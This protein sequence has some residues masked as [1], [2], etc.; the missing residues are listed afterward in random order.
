[1]KHTILSH[2]VSGIKV[3]R[4]ILF[5]AMYEAC[6]HAAADLLEAT[7]IDSNHLLLMHNA[8]DWGDICNEDVA[9]NNRGLK[10][11]SMLV[12]T[13]RLVSNEQLAETPHALRNQL[14]TLLVITDAALDSKKPLKRHITTILCREDY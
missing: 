5:Q 7:G 12:S 13:F 8:G 14:P 3:S 10:T 1:V 2:S 11:G 9:I 4:P 6:T